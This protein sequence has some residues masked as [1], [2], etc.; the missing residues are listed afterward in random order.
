VIDLLT[1]LVL[2][3]LYWLLF[4]FSASKPSTL[5][6][7]IAFLLF[8]IFWVD[9][10]GVHLAA[11]SINNLIHALAE[12][13]IIDVTGS[14]LYH[15]TYF[16]DEHLSH[17]MWHIGLVGLA[18]VLIYREWHS[19]IGQKTIWWATGL[20]GVIYGFTY[21]VVFLEGQTTPLGLPFALL[22]VLFT[23][24]WGRNKLAS[25]P[26]LAF[27]FLTCLVAGLLFA[28]WGIYWGGFPQFTDVGLI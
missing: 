1:P 2:I 11:N 15:L 26:V 4:K 18:A 8:A 27:F 21:F 20:G 3:P 25:Q 9:G 23:L 7:E 10:H 12:Q 19:P 5:T 13:G 6:E 14:D 17:Y 28:S 24:V 16:F 22:I